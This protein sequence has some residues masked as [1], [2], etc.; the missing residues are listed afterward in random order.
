[1]SRR[2]GNENKFVA[3]SGMAGLGAG[4]LVPGVVDLILIPCKVILAGLGVG[5]ADVKLISG[6]S[7]LNARVPTDDTVCIP[8]PDGLELAKSSG[9]TMNITG[10]LVQVTLYYT[11]KDESP[12][13]TKSAS[14]AASLNPI[15]TRNPGSSLLGDQS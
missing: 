7:F 6:E 2:F 5:P 3:Q 1:M 13:I 10:N 4:V 12:G 9:I 11:V 15:T 14:R 8:F